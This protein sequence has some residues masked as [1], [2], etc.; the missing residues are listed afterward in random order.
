VIEKVFAAVV[1]AACA[2]LLVRLS[3][4]RRRARFDAAVQAATYRTRHAVRRWAARADL[5]W[6]RW[7]SWWVGRRATRHAQRMAADAINRARR[8]ASGPGAASA[9]TELRDRKRDTLH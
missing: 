8:K 1:V 9:P 6:R 7:R 3:L 2:V 5:R 4:G